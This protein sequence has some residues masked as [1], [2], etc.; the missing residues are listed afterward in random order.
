MDYPIK[1]L[2]LKDG[3]LMLL[4][5]FGYDHTNKRIWLFRYNSLGDLLWQNCYAQEDTLVV[6]EESFDL[7]YAKDSSYLISGFCYYPYPGSLWPRKLHPYLICVDTFGNQ[8]WDTPLGVQDSVL[9]VNLSSI[10]DRKG[11]IYSSGQNYTDN[12]K[13]MLCKTSANGDYLWHK[14]ILTNTQGGGG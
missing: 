9:G 5:Y 1:I 10:A 2:S 7:A 6:G 8:V 3:Y 14:D 11:N 12:L 4:R 13:P